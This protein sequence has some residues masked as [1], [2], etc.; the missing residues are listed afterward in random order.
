LDLETDSQAD[1]P[2]GHLLSKAIPA[3]QADALG[4]IKVVA[5]V[6]LET[7]A[8]GKHIVEPQDVVLI[9][10]IVRKRELQH[11]AD[12]AVER[13]EAGGRTPSGPQIQVLR[14]R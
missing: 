4:E 9:P 10:E 7:G 3:D 5:G 1:R 13:R 11:V 8:E 2:P 6:E 14:Q 12:R